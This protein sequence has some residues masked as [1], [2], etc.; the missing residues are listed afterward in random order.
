[1]EMRYRLYAGRMMTGFG[2]LGLEEGFLGVVATVVDEVDV[3]GC[4]G[5]C[6]R[7]CWGSLEEELETVEED[8]TS[9][10]CTCPL[11]ICGC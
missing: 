7:C 2:A 8:P 9:G 6:C 10:D 3:E 1:M 4:V 5:S 11:T